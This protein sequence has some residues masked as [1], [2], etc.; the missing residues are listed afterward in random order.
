MKKQFL[1]FSS[2]GKMV[3]IDINSIRFLQVDNDN[4]W[5]GTT[6]FKVKVYHCMKTILKHL[7][8]DQFFQVHR[9]FAVNINAVTAI[10]RNELVID[11]LFIPASPAFQ[12]A[13][14][15][16]RFLLN[17]VPVKQLR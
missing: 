14:L 5:I 2:A 3:K 11:D 10:S 15:F 13:N 16:K 4:C 7:P 6:T 8:P 9:S 17:T 1:L 12:T